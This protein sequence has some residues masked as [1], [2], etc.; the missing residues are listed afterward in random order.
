MMTSKPDVV[1]EAVMAAMQARGMTQTALAAAA[2]VP[3]PNLSAWLGGKSTITTVTA[4]RILGTL[5][6]GVAL[7]FPTITARGKC[8]LCGNLI[9]S[10]YERPPCPPTP[11]SSSPT[12]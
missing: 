4:S 12:P 9:R 8:L 6:L 10:S 1:R 3:Q 2:D 7:S 5:G 11:R